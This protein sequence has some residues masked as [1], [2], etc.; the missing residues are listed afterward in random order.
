MPENA[1][2][3]IKG[4]V[5]EKEISS[6]WINGEPEQRGPP[7]A[8]VEPE[9][10]NNVTFVTFILEQESRSDTLISTCAVPID[11]FLADF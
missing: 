1:L 3:K 5:K 10:I 2:Y 6:V 7:D 11:Q 9:V 4:Q 8:E